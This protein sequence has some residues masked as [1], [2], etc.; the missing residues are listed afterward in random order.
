MNKVLVAIVFA[1]IVWGVDRWAG[2][3]MAPA[4][5]PTLGAEISHV[6][7]MC[8]IFVPWFYAVVDWIVAGF[9]WALGGAR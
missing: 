1:V 5:P 6:L 2:R 8:A 4:E 3:D 7:R 9:A